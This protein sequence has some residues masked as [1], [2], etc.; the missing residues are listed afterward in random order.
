MRAT[1]GLPSLD[2]DINTVALGIMQPYFR[3]GDPVRPFGALRSTCLFG[4]LPHLFNAAHVETEMVQA[5]FFFRPLIQ[6]GEIK[7]TVGDEY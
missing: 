2:R 1:S 7:I 6:Q 4:S 5:E 3:K